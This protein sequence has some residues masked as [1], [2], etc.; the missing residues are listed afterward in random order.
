MNIRIC[1]PGQRNKAV[2]LSYDDG[3]KQDARL[4]AIMQEFGLRGTF[5]IN[6]GEYA[7]EG[8]EGT[9]HGRMT[10]LQCRKLYQDSG[11]EVAVHGLTHPFLDRLA[12]ELCTYEILQDRINLEQ[13]FDCIVRGMAYPYGSYSDNVVEILKNCGIAYARTVRS[14]GRFDLPTDWLRLPATCHHNDPRL[15]ELAEKFLN[16]NTRDAKLFY[17]WGHSYEFDDHNNWNVIEDFAKLV[18]NRS[19]VWYATNIEVFDYITAFHRLQFSVVS[20]KVHNPTAIELCFAT[21]AGAYCVKPG[22]TVAY[23]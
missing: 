22:E 18:G 13:D 2:T 3:V 20:K 12:H 21:D 17:L 15:M 5:N 19:D 23:R 4:I 11:M 16:E 1:F 8:S 10:R 9:A 7:P 14:T 6:S